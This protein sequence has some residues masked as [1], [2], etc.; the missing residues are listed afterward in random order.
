MVGVRGRK[1]HRYFVVC[2]ILQGAVRVIAG[3][4]EFQKWMGRER[5]RGLENGQ[6]RF[7]RGLGK[8]LKGGANY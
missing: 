2:G 8:G 3:K 5:T 7:C 1:G 4:S 6:L